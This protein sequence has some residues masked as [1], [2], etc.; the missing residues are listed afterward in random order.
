MLRLLITAILFLSVVACRD[1]SQI[2]PQR[3]SILQLVAAPDTWNG[4]L[5]QTIGF[6]RLEHE[7]DALYLHED[8]FRHRLSDNA[9]GVD[10]P[11][12][13]PARAKLSMNYVLVEGVFRAAD[14]RDAASFP[15]T[16]SAVQRA[17][18]WSS[19]E[20]P[21]ARFRTNTQ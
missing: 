3:V 15:G 20:D 6:L 14:P 10:I 8:D 17:E 18:V 2:V 7:G 19:P 9:V 16:I 1:A 11:E 21:G 5:V 13:F 12:R 4:K